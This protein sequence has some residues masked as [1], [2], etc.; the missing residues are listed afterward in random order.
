MNSLEVLRYLKTIPYHSVGVFPADQIPRVWIKPTAYVFNTDNHQK[1]GA[2]WV[3]VYA[4]K[5]GNALF[6]DSYG[7]APTVPEHINRLRKNCKRLR[8]NTAQLQ[9]LT[10]DVCGQFCIM[11]LYYMSTGLGFDKFMQHFS[12]DFQK[13]DEVA[14]NFVSRKRLRRDNYSL[15]GRGGGHYV[16]CMQS[17]RCRMTHLR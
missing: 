2:H 11:F 12:T 1:P 17:S 4:D 9:S 3:S 6:F 15:N 13:N 8:W 16:R 7:F 5:S 14:R 10:S